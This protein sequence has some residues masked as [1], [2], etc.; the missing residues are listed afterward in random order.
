[1]YIFVS[2]ANKIAKQLINLI[3]P[4]NARESKV[5]PVEIFKYRPF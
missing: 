4:K 3:D 1:V 5:E 2:D